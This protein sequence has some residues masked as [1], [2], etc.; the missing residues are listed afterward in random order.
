MDTTRPGCLFV[1]L[2]TLAFLGAAMTLAAVR[3]RIVHRGHAKH[4]VSVRRHAAVMHGR[5]GWLVT[6]KRGKHGRVAGRPVPRLRPGAPIA[7]SIRAKSKPAPTAKR[8]APKAV[9]VTKS[10]LAANRIDAG[11]GRYREVVKMLNTGTV[12]G[13]VFLGYV[14]KTGPGLVPTKLI[15]EIDLA[16]KD[17]I[18]EYY[19]SGGHLIFV[20]ET[21]RDYSFD[22]KT[23]AFD[24]G[25]PTYKEPTAIPFARGHIVGGPKLRSRERA[26]LF[27][28]RYL[29][30]LLHAK[31]TSVDVQ[32]WIKS[33][34]I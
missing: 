5:R 4:H 25:H 6:A 3:P 18:D 20:R 32:K 24:F 15:C 28:S 19:Y 12:R 33:P 29:L 27:D 34:Q 11:L 23:N 26:L 10:E 14:P 30:S 8:V 13:G 16:N 2:V 17:V 9:R 7:V 22:R 21:V 31:G 1:L